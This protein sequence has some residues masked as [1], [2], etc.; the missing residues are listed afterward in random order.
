MVEQVSPGRLTTKARFWSLVN[1][2]GICGRQSGTGIGFFFPLS[3]L[4]FVCYYP[5]T[6]APYS[7][8]KVTLMPYNVSN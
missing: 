7:F 3:T 1:A 6:N 2:C 8:V 4:V 5:S